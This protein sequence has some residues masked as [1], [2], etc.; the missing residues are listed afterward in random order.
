MTRIVCS[1]CRTE[2]CAEGL[3]LCEDARQ[4]GYAAAGYTHA[5]QYRDKGSD[6]LMADEV[7]MVKAQI[8]AVDAWLD[9][10]CGPSYKAQPLA[11]TWARVCKFDE[12]HGESVAELILA[13]G[14]NPRKPAD[15]AAR[16][17]LT[18]EL[19]DRMCSSFGAIMHL[20]KDADAAW[21]EFRLSLAR[22][23]GR[24]GD[25]GYPS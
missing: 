11:Q 6:A 5:R 23:A 3:F 10:E 24:A 2:A 14:Q 21:L 8:T 16:D 12:E 22:A 15:P 18:A 25:A 17:R 19:G 13:S 1:A 9:G 7:A 4:A 20:V